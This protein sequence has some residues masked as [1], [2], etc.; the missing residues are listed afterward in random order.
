[1]NPAV[2]P[3]DRR[4]YRFDDFIVDPVRRLLLR[5]G[6]PVAVTPKAVSLLLALLERPGEVVDKAELF[7]KIWP[8][9]YVT[10]ANLTQNVSFLR[11]A[12]GESAQARRYVATVPGQGYSFVG[13]VQIL[14]ADAVELPPLRSGESGIWRL[15]PAEALR[16]APP[17]PAIQPATPAAPATPVVPPADEPRRRLGAVALPLALV[18]LL[19]IAGVVWLTAR[20]AV[21]PAASSGKAGAVKAGDARGG[22]A[23][24][25]VAVLG[26]KNLTGAREA[27]WLAPALA[28]TLSTELGAGAN[29]RMISGENVARARKALSL[30]YSES[31]ASYDMER[32]RSFLGADLV[33]VGSYVYMGAGERR[34]IRLDIRVLKL[35]GGDALA[36]VIETGTETE[37][38]DLVARTG[39]DLR[40]ELRLADLS[41][42][43][44]R[45]A[46]ARHP[47]S[48]E[49]MRLYTQG[50]AHLRAYDFLAARDLLLQA[51]QSDPSS[52][53]IHSALALA[54][55]D[56]G[57]DARAVAEA[58]KAREL[59]GPLSREDKLKLDA[60]FYVAGRQWRKASEIYRSL[61]T[62][63][64]D[65]LEYGLRLVDSLSQAGVSKEA[66]AT[67]GEL[68]KLP[69]PASDD[70]RIDVMEA[71]A[72]RRMSDMA[73]CGRAAAAAVS[74]G[75]LL[76]E[77]H[78]VGQG[79]LLQGSVPLFTGRP[80]DA[81]A[82]FQEARD[83]FDRTGYRWGVAMAEAHIGL[84]LYRNGDF[85]AAQPEMQKAVAISREIGNVS[86]I[87]G[88]LANLGLLY[89]N[90]GDFQRALTL[91]EQSR[92]RFAEIDD[93][94]LKQ[95]VL[96]SW[97]YVKMNL[98]DLSAAEET[99]EKVLEQCR[100]AGNRSDEARALANLGSILAARGSLA[101]ARGYFEKSMEILHA[102]HDPSFT[103]PVLV[104]SVDV[105]ARLGD[106]A[107]ARNRALEG[108]AAARQDGQR[109]GTARILGA[110]ANLALRTGDLAAARSQAEEQLQIA[111]EIGARDLIA[112]ALQSRGRAALAAGDLSGARRDLEEALRASESGGET[113]LVSA[114]RLDLAR[115]ALAEGRPDEAARVA[116]HAAAW[117]GPRG[118]QVDEAWALS[119]LAEA[120]FQQGFTAEARQTA[121]EARDHLDDS[122]DLPMRI[123]IS[124]RLS[125]LGIGGEAAKTVQ[126]LRQAISQA[127]RS[128]LTPAGLEARLALGVLLLNQSDGAAGRAELAAVRGDAETRGLGLLAKRAAE[129]AQRSRSDA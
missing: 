14:P 117:S 88:G 31:G 63:F 43:E 62:F 26:F 35:P 34:R 100:R 83:I 52:A 120:L 1:M 110:L 7:Q 89:L 109:L 95:R 90:Q 71:S 57:Y 29:V 128:G 69:R 42:E 121:L 119:L 41:P 23:R 28:E 8:D 77:S 103:A 51:V 101:Q 38:F 105:L 91:L 84:A 55:A 67:I 96:Y 39:A 20:K 30:P 72:A 122:D 116:R 79:L 13:E 4:L 16:E 75:R 22:G 106:V 99:S 92:D 87:A 64:P 115:L 86:G 58:S 61:W 53:L 9:T 129:L 125:P 3:T 104:S 73:T 76:G 97:A 47:A 21:S 112:S 93:E 70:P 56:L 114:I 85:A 27:E 66:M 65:D 36:S 126:D 6:E 127:S 107:V 48:P 82:P 11:K 81:L 124:A 44:A 40:R 60:S 24:P 111:R 18:A 78:V 2:L 102:V 118:A 49:A 17:E 33:V 15:V 45:E 59:A 10:D 80:L 46:E 113:L 74:K 32:L 19:T 123:V 98:G 94:L 12:L 50:L 37:L 25:A 54:W 5:N 108:L 68:R